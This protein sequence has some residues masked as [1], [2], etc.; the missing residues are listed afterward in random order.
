MYCIVCVCGGKGV[1]VVCIVLCVCGGGCLCLL[2]VLLC[3]SP[4]VIVMVSWT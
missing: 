4:E 3:G 2:C 1:F